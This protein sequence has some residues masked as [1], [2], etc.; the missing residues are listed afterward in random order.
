MKFLATLLLLIS[1]SSQANV[2][3]S[4]AKKFCASTDPG[5][6]QLAKCLDDYLGQLSPA[7]AKEL[8]DFKTKTEK[9]NPCFEEL[10]EY[11]ESIPTDNRKLEYCLLKNESRLGL[12]CAADFKKKKSD[13][14]VKD[15][16]AQDIVNTCYSTLTESDA[17][18]AKCL[19]TNKKKVS[20]F[21]HKILDKKITEMKKANPCF[22]ETDKY[23][24][25]QVQFVDIHDCMEKKLNV[26]TPKCKKVVQDEIN[27]ENASPCYMDLR[28]HCKRG[29]NATD[30]HRCLTINEKELSNSCKQF[31]VTE[32]EKLKKM[33]DLC[34]VDRLKFCP[35]APFQ[36]GM[37]L[38][39]LKENLSKVTPACKALL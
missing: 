27:K 25:T 15:L 1:M 29:L 4:D 5:K 22:D 21:C 30:Q 14:I 32:A 18:T 17:A 11:C 7:C 26:L 3:D 10:A 16:C 31:R 6:G 24:P 39:C 33:V 38:K 12:K 35:K 19:I 8:K 13:M 9:K 36:N 34:E 37:I 23:C 2:C 28:K 20:A